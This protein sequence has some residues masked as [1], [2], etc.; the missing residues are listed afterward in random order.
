MAT[1][2]N[3]LAW[4]IPWT[5]GPDGLQSM[6]SQRVRHDWVTNTFTFSEREIMEG[7]F[8]CIDFK[9]FY[10]VSPMLQKKKEKNF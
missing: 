8:F 2:S 4:R 10:G 9:L 6:G 7:F 5:V 1:H 3:I